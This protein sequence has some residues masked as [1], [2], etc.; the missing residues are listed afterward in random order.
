MNWSILYNSCFEHP[1][2][3]AFYCWLMKN[4]LVNLIC[5]LKLWLIMIYI[6]VRDWNIINYFSKYKKLTSWVLFTRN[7]YVNKFSNEWEFN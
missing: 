1:L 7:D 6:Y 2:I 3:K 5:Y 4:Y